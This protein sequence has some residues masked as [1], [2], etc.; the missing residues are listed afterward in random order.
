MTSMTNL[1]STFSQLNFID[2]DSKQIK[3][4]LKVI[5]QTQYIRQKWMMDQLQQDGY[6]Q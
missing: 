3:M 4:Q 5:E 1:S 6:L 2:T